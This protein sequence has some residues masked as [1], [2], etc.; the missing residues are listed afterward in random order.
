MLPGFLLCTFSVLFGLKRKGGVTKGSRRSVC[1]NRLHLQLVAVPPPRPFLAW[2][3]RCTTPPSCTRAPTPKSLTRIEI[4][5]TNSLL[6]TIWA[7]P[8][9]LMK[10]QLSFH[11]TLPVCNPSPARTDKSQTKLFLSLITDAM[12]AYK[13]NNG[14]SKQNIWEKWVLKFET[15]F[16]KRYYFLYPILPNPLISR[17]VGFVVVVFNG[18]VFVVVVVVVFVVI[19]FVVAVIVIVIV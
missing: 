7:A 6:G 2:S 4:G 10:M 18:V 15:M 1:N 9:Y 12:C 19:V 17:P 3:P 5:Q 16:E 13:W 11:C 14:H 8:N